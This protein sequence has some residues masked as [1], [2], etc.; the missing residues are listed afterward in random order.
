MALG[1]PFELVD[2]KIVQALAIVF[3]ADIDH[4]HRTRSEF[5]YH[6]DIL[7]MFNLIVCGAATTGPPSVGS[8]QS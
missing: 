1:N 6:A 3:L 5:F 7:K 2:Q 8:R 4:S